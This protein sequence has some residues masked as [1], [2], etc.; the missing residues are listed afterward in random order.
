MKVE[1]TILK[2][3]I[4]NEKYVR[5]V[6]PHLKEEYFPEQNEKKLYKII[7]DYITKYNNIPSY[8]SLSIILEDSY[9]DN[10]SYENIKEVLHEIHN[11]NEVSDL[12]WLIDLTEQYCKDSAIYNAI[13]DSVNILQGKDK[14]LKKESIPSLLSDAISVTFDNQVGHDYLEG[15][16]ERY[17][18]YT[19]KTNRFPFHL[20]M[21]NK[22]T[23]GGLK[24]GTLNLVAAGCVDENTQVRIRY[25]RNYK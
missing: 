25:K 19:E 12:D 21:M 17:K 10:I 20:N 18:I 13:Q 5:K 8:E 4:K 7:S 22:V 14:K 11:D 6:L 3:L 1:L 2:N 15:F 9:A 16:E 23:N 24:S